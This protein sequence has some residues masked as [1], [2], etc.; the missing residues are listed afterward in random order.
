MVLG[1]RNN[2]DM[3]RLG[4]AI[5]KRRVSRAVARN[6]VKRLIR[7]SFRIHQRQ[8]AGLDVVVIA[9]SGVGNVE[10]TDFFLSLA[11][12]WKKIRNRCDSS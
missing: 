6:R 10:S 11:S 3:P 2:L 7:E 5:S 8:L 4:L 1:R 12:H 9:R